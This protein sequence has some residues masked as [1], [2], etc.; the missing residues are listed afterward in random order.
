LAGP[1]TTIYNR[2]NRWSAQWLWR[3]LFERLAAAGNIP[4]EFSI[5]STHI[6]KQA[7]GPGADR[8]PK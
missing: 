6:C 4:D 2:Y 1:S 3:K 5:D 8:R 7:W